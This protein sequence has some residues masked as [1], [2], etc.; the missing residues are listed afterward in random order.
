[1]L[2][3]MIRFWIIPDADSPYSARNVG[4]TAWSLVDAKSLVIEA[5]HF[6]GWTDEDLIAFDN[7]AYVPDID[8]RLLDQGHIIPNM[9]P[10]NFRGVWWPRANS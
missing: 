8:I 6:L 9:G 5:A 1:M 10:V 2:K 3:F 7:A 4:V